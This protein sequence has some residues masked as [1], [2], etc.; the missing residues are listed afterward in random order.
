M[1]EHSVR[2]W[3][4]PEPSVVSLL[5]AARPL[6]VIAG[7]LIALQSSQS[8]DTPKVVFF[9]IAVLALTGSVLRVWRS[10]ESALVEAARPWLITSGII[11][12]IVGLSLPVALSNGT[13]VGTWVRDAASYALI[14]AAPWLA[15]D[16]GASVSSRVAAYAMVVTG[17]LA[18]ASYTINWLQRRQIVDLP[19]DRLVLPSF[20]LATGFFAFAVARAIWGGRDR[21]A[22]AI[23]SAVVI[24]LLLATGTRTAVAL[25][26]I[27][28]VLL[29][30]AARIGGLVRLRTSL[31]PAVA[32]LLVMAVV[33]MP[34]IL[35]ALSAPPPRQLV[36]T[37]SAVAT[38]GSLA[39]PA[40]IAPVS[41]DP[42]GSSMTEPAPAATPAPTPTPQDGGRFGTIDDVVSGSD[43]SLRLRWAQ[44]VAAWEI[45]VSSPIVGRGL[46][47]SIPWI[48]VDGTLVNY[49]LADTPVTVLAK[50]G[51]FGIVIWAAIGWATV[52]TLRRARRL[53]RPAT[54]ARAALLGLATGLILLSPFGAQLEDKGTGLA[55]ILLLGLAFAVIRTAE[56]DEPGLPAC[57]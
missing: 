51:L 31:L 19:I 46:G 2:A 30:D 47:V 50:F 44:T 11:A 37:P 43:A 49:F 40:S 8:L 52:V 55:L 7:A 13:P 34:G 28:I 17:S 48:N 39:P 16:L 14:V 3:R 33:A 45:F 53:G 21:Y 38:P 25:A 42:V 54:V 10:R 22:W 26:A 36:A 56:P 29:V 57:G 32:P 1:R 23:A 20:A 5:G 18:T 35:S 24:G 15:L 6:A 4:A 9:A 12:A 41:P 27:P